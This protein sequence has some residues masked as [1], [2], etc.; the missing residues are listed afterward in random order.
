MRPFDDK[1]SFLL[2]QVSKIAK[3]NG[4]EAGEGPLL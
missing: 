3:I 2:K 4:K 1:L